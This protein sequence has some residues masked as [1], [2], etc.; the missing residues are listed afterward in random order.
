[1]IASFPQLHFRKLV[2][3][4]LQFLEAHNVWFRR[5]KPVEQ[6]G[7]AAIEVVDF[8]SGDL[9]GATAMVIGRERP[10]TGLLFRLLHQ[11]RHRVVSAAL[12]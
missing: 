7:K 4:G 3:V 8:E 5:P 6:I 1:L 9:H 12:L 11:P 2:V 10:L